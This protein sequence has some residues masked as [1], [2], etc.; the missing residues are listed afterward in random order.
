MKISIKEI[1]DYGLEY[2]KTRMISLEI[3]NALN[4]GIYNT[5]IFLF[6]YYF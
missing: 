3:A 5:N 2:G 1:D 4:L 6:F